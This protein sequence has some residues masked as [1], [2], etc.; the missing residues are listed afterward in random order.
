[1]ANTSKEGK[2]LT[3]RDFAYYRRRNQNRIHAALASF[4][5]EEA[6]AGRITKKRLAESTGRDPSQITKCL[7]EPSNYEADTTSDILLAMGAEMDYS[8]ARFADRPKPNYVHP[9]MAPYAAQISTK[10]QPKAT[11]TEAFTPVIV[12]IGKPPSSPEAPV[13]RLQVELFES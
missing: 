11:T 1:M 8:V 5:A 10:L 13:L 2:T 12:K 9:V 6:E 7:T 3:L 4:F